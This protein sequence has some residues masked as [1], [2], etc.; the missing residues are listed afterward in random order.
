[1]KRRDHDDDLVIA[2][3]SNPAPTSLDVVQ[4]WRKRSEVER[5]IITQRPTRWGRYAMMAPLGDKIGIADFDI[6]RIKRSRISTVQPMIKNPGHI[7]P[8]DNSKDQRL[9]RIEVF[10]HFGAD[11]HT[12]YPI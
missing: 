1:M 4:H 9:F 2:A 8:M 6:V 7:I 3:F 5:N 11:S 10:G 12:P